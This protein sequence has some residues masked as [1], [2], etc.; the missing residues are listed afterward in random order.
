M[1]PVFVHNIA[2]VHNVH[3]PLAQLVGDP[4]LEL[5]AGERRHPG[6]GAGGVPG[7]PEGVMCTSDGEYENIKCH[8][9]GTKGIV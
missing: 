7:V 3:L 9:L 6:E 4:L 8:R 1:W 5:R 2:S